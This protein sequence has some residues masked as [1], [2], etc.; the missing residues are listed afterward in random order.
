MAAV[1]RKSIMYCEDGEDVDTADIHALFVKR[2]RFCKEGIVA[3]KET[4]VTAQNDMERAAFRVLLRRVY[5]L[6]EEQ[7]HYVSVGFY[8]SDNYQV[9]VELGVLGSC[10]SDSPSITSER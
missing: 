3:S 9:L 10:L 5:F 7:I 8:P 6:N 2:A 4:T 1:P